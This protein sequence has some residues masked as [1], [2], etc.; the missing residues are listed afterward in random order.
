LIT[1][2]NTHATVLESYPLPAGAI[3]SSLAVGSDGNVWVADEALAAIHRVTIG[4]TIASFNTGLPSGLTV[5]GIASAPDGNLYFTAPA[6]TTGSIPEVGRITTSGAITMIARLG[7]NAAPYY[8]NA[9][10]SG[11]VCSATIRR[12]R[13]RSGAWRRQRESLPSIRFQASAHPTCPTTEAGTS[14]A[15]CS[16]GPN[17][18]LWLGGSGMIYRA[19]PPS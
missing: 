16:F 12:D 3:P 6:Q 18:N 2:V 17:G 1:I 15:A 11:N 5:Q 13:M 14:R 19:K 10:S 8:L 7:S 4:G 9:D